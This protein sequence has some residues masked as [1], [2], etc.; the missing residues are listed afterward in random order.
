MGFIGLDDEVNWF[1]RWKYWLK[2]LRIIR[3]E[4]GVNGARR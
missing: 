1:R 4:D 3:I 2:K